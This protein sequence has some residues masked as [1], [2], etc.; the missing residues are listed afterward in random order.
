VGVWDLHR[1]DRMGQAEYGEGDGKANST[2][3]T[4]HTVFA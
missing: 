2:I 1:L 3:E 4:V